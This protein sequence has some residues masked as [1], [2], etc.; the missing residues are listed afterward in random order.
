MHT[1]ATAWLWEG[2]ARINR[3]INPNVSLASALL[4]FCILCFPDDNQVWVADT[5][6]RDIEDPQA[7]APIR[8]AMQH[9]ADEIPDLCDQNEV[10]H[11]QQYMQCDHCK[12][13][14]YSSLML[15]PVCKLLVCNDCLVPQQLC[16]SCMR[17][18]QYIHRWMLRA[19]A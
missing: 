6:A 3:Q 11:R 19:R 14:K 13:Y 17:V 8:A 9:I 7:H 10:V 12:H 1:P 2:K 18:K 16:V 15:C 4:Q 5:F